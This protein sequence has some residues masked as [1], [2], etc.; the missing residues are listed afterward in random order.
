MLTTFY[1]DA[2]NVEIIKQFQLEVSEMAIMQ[3]F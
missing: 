2:K 1:K 3:I